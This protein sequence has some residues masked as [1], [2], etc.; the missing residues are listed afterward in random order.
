MTDLHLRDIE[1]TAELVRERLQSNHLLQPLADAGRPAM[2]GYSSTDVSWNP[3][4]E[5][6][7]L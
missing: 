3:A 5:M 2:L 7:L 6:T 1:M 4:G